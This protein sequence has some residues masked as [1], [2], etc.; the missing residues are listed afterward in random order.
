MHK[1]SLLLLVTIISQIQLLSAQSRIIT[2]TVKS[3]HDNSKLSGV[4]VTLKDSSESTYTDIDGYYSLTL[5]SNKGTLV[6]SLTEMEIKEIR[7][8]SSNVVDVAMNL[9]PRVSEQMVSTALDIPRKKESLG[10]AVQKLHN[11]EINS[12]KASGLS[13][14]LS[15]K[16]SGAQ[17]N[18]TG[19]LW[20]STDII[21]RGQSSFRSNNQVL[22]VVDGIPVFNETLNSSDQRRGGYGFDYGNI[23]S[24]IHPDDIESISVLKGTAAGVIYGSSGRNGVIMV[25]TKKG[26]KKLNNGKNIEVR[27]NSTFLIE[28]I[29]KSTFPKYQREYGAGYGLYNNDSTISYEYPGLD[30]YLDVNKD[31]EIDYTVPYSEDGSMGQKFDPNLMVYHFDAAEPSSPNYLKASPWIAAANGPETFFQ[32]ALN[33]SNGIA[34]SGQVKDFDFRLS[35][36]NLSKAGVLPNSSY[37]R[38]N[39]TFNGRYRIFDKLKASS[40][41]AY[42]ESRAKGRNTTG[43]S[44][45]TLASFRQNFQVNVDMKTLERLYNETNRNVT[46]NRSSFDDPKPMYWDNPYWVSYQNYQSDQRTHLYGIAQLEYTI[47]E[48]L[49]L[50]GRYSFGA[51]KDRQE[52]RKAIGSAYS[53]FGD[54][55]VSSGYSKLTHDFYKANLNLILNYTRD[56]TKKIYLDATLGFDKH[57]KNL[58]RHFASTSGGLVIPNRYNLDN[59]VDP[60]L[61]PEVKKTSVSPN[62]LFGLLTLGYN[63]TLFF[64][65]AYRRERWGLLNSSIKAVSNYSVSTGF[66]FDRFLH[67]EFIN[68]GKLRLNYARVGHVISSNTDFL[69]ERTTSYESGLEMHFFKSRLGVDVTFYNRNSD[70][71]SL[72]ISGFNSR[73]HTGKMENKGAE[74]M[75]NMTPVSSRHFEWNVA[76]NWSKN[77]NTVKELYSEAGSGTSI[78][79]IILAPLQG[80]IEIAAKVGESYPV[81]LGTN[82]VYDSI[83]GGKVVNQVLGTYAETGH[84]GEII[85]HVAPLY[86]MGI[87]NTLSYKNLTLSF[88][89]D[90]QKGGDIFSLDQRYG[91]SYGLYVETAGL[92]DLGNPVRDPLKVIYDEKGNIMGYE[93]T[94]GGYLNEGTDGR[95][96]ANII[97]APGDTP[98]GRAYSPDAQYVYDAT[99]IK[100]REVALSYTFPSALLDKTPIKGMSLAFIGSNLWILH[101]VLPHADP[102]FSQSAGPIRGWQSGVMPALRSFGMNL[103]VQF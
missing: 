42:V 7:I 35:Y 102:E 28:T 99:Y 55:G 74:I 86:N 5:N 72:N 66:L 80:G 36:I 76:M 63:K 51:Y 90:I 26:G 59:S 96:N 100:L 77:K 2:G 9:L 78:V 93:A 103:S 11:E 12:V 98:W 84:S 89:I 39:L 17:I 16:I 79:Q 70:N 81:I 87:S 8:G 6:F 92:N 49:S 97:R 54:Q 38:N 40:T 20:G 62:I 56:L 60:A 61:P 34:V 52:E 94:S 85:G 1:S 83:T 88:L 68:F 29:D 67:L 31:G 58:E 95:G 32:R 53:S 101:K 48:G 46:W 91:Q 3:A 69:P 14:A 65:G 33:Y 44:G 75:L 18:N 22:F 21:I 19:N 25:N 82:Y 30:Y 57:K 24:D 73:F 27:F 45:N 23:I 10:F 41:I 15:G 13:S 71:L 37:K 4:K 64:D 47:V 50:T 43:Y